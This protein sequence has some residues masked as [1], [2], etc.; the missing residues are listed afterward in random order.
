MVRSC[1]VDD[2]EGWAQQVC[3]GAGARHVTDHAEP[4]GATDRGWGCRPDSPGVNGP[5]RDGVLNGNR[6]RVCSNVSLYA[7]SALIHRTRTCAQLHS[8]V[9]RTLVP[10]SAASVRETGLEPVAGWRQYTVCPTHAVAPQAL[11][12]DYSSTGDEIAPRTF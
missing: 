8:P 3:G 1:V 11:T 5:Q 12:F 6:F 4:H 2:K 9:E 7:L 10:P